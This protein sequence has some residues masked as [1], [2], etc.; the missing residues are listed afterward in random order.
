MRFTQ[1]VQS[2]KTK[3]LTAVMVGSTAILA[4]GASAQEAVPPDLAPIVWPID[5][6]SI[7]VSV[8]AAGATMIGLWAIYKIGFRLVRK[9]IS[10][11]GSVV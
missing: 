11:M 6:S 2:A 8:A 5:L 1:L 7:A 4:T 3:T 10:R 9:F